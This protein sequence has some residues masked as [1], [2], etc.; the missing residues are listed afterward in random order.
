MSTETS[1]FDAKGRRIKI[2]PSGATFVVTKNGKQY[3]NKATFHKVGK[4]LIRIR[5]H[6]RIPFS[7]RNN[8]GNSNSG[9]NLNKYEA[10]MN[11]IKHWYKHLFEHLGWMIIAKAKGHGYKVTAYKK[12]VSELL[13]TILKTIPA[14]TE[15]NHK[16]NLRIMA[17]HVKLLKRR[18]SLLI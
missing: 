12:S 14:Y 4:K 15:S 6:K 5:K 16:R 7:M 8:A 11:G 3:G 1:N 9:G 17:K 2:G 13:K 18:A 10:T